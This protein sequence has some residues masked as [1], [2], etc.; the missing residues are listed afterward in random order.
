MKKG[1]G[2]IKGSGRGESSV[3]ST[4]SSHRTVYFTLVKTAVRKQ[5]G[6][7]DCTSKLTW[8]NWS[9]TFRSGAG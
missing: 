1:N 7:T 3:Q 8:N 4:H 5:E 9:T 2:T 6:I